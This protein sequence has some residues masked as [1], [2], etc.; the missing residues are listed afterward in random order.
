MVKFFTPADVETAE[1]IQ[2]RGGTTTG[3]SRSYKYSGTIFRRVQS[4]TRSETRMPL[5]PVERVM[6]LPSDQSIV[7]FAGKHHPL[8]AG[9]RPYW[10]IPRVNRPSIGPPDR[11]AKRALS[12]SR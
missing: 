9:R 5:L 2:R 7:F 11:R 10:T 1:Y 6:G 8:L 4:E 12:Q 3:E